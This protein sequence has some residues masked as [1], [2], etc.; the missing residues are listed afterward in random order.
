MGRAGPGNGSDFAPRL[1]RGAVKPAERQ[2][3]AQWLKAEVA[4]LEKG[5]KAGEPEMK[6][7][8]RRLKNAALK[9]E[10]VNGST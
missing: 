6:K 1:S 4:R 8:I 2:S 10:R 5:P 7:K 9:L 3:M